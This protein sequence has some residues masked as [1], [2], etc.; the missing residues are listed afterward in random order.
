[1]DTE[2]EIKSLLTQL[3]VTEEEINILSYE[4]SIEY[5]K[6]HHGKIYGA[7]SILFLGFDENETKELSKKAER[8]YLRV[9]K[10][11]SPNLRF[12][13]TTD[14]VDLKRIE[15]AREFGAK[16][17]SRNLF[18]LICAKNN[19]N[20][21]NDSL[22]FDSSIPKNVQIA[23]PLSNFNID[24]EVDSLSLTDDKKYTVNIHQ[25]I[26][27]CRDFKDKNRE[28]YKIGDLRRLCKH[29]IHEYRESFGIIGLPDFNKFI[30][31]TGYPLYE[32]FEYLTLENI[33]QPV[34][35]N[36]NP[37]ED[38]CNIYIQDEK[39]V[40]TKYG[41]SSSEERF[42]YDEK[43][44]GFV[45]EL[46]EKLKSLKSKLSD[47]KVTQTVIKTPN[48]SNKNKAQA[49]LK[50]AQGCS[51]VLLFSFMIAIVFYFIS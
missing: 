31:K 23:K 35:V 27:S 12:I 1:M 37:A 34:I 33:S 24:V 40:F 21:L 30:I 14:K 50:E 22:F 28:R 36:F 16:E 2:K 17:I 19:Y 29:L 5:L 10:K 42:S 4:S 39:G 43:P 47:N 51:S 32:K 6:F 46:R 7:S 9:S 41:Y 3:G 44:H 49:N 13:C 45:K 48:S 20:L 38:W 15:K 11:V 8:S 25:Q 18:D 26:C